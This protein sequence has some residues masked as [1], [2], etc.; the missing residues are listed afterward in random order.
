M[1][2]PLSIRSC[3]LHGPTKRPSCARMRQNFRISYCIV[4]LILI[5]R[6]VFRPSCVKTLIDA[7]PRRSSHGSILL[8]NLGIVS[9]ATSL[10]SVTSTRV[11]AASFTPLTSVTSA[12]VSRCAI[13]RSLVTKM[14]VLMLSRSLAA[15]R[16]A[17]SLSGSTVMLNAGSLRPARP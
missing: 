7:S 17:Q 4:S 15:L 11:L 8:R 14:S 16:I 1:T 13:P 3:L 12:A 2:K 6:F 5:V 10:F 9:R